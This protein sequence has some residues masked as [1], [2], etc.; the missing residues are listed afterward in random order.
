MSQK[1]LDAHYQGR[2]PVGVRPLAR[3]VEAQDEDGAFAT[4]MDELRS[5]RKRSHWMWFVFPQ[6]AG[7]GRSDTARWFAIDSLAE[8]SAFLDDPVLSARLTLASELVLDLVP[9]P[10]TEVFGPTDAVKLRS[11]MTLFHR[12]AP[13]EP[14]FS[15]VL[16]R[17]FDGVPDPLTDRLLADAS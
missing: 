11:S 1:G 12:A 14:V 17:C 2:H 3:F 6:L 5:G 9:R 8:A 10:M 7:L 4:A 16:D 15:A 13:D